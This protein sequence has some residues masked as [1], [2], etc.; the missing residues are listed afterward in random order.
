MSIKTRRTSL[1][2]KVENEL[3]RIINISSLKTQRVVRIIIVIE[4]GS[5]RA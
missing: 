1:R 4:E 5:A 2:K 3:I